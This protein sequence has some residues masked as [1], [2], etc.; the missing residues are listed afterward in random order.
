MLSRGTAGDEPDGERNALPLLPLLC[1]LPLLLLFW[2]LLLL[3][4]LFLF[5]C[6]ASCQLLQNGVLVVDLD[7]SLTFIERL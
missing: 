1:L 2:L 3:L 7:C 6:R 4:L 5:A